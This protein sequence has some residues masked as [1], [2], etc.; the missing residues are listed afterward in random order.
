[1]LLIK[2]PT[3]LTSPDP[4]TPLVPDIVS[5]ML[6][7]LSANDLSL[8]DGANVTSW[9]ASDGTAPSGFKTFNQKGSNDN[10]P[11]F[12]NTNGPGGGKCVEANGTMILRNSGLAS[13]QAQP[14]TYG[15]VYRVDA[16]AASTL[17]TRIIAGQSGKLQNFR[18]SSTNV[19][20]LDAGSGK[21]T[22]SN[23]P[24]GDWLVAVYTLNGSSSKLITYDTEWSGNPG[25]HALD[26]IGFFG[27]DGNTG[28]NY[29]DGAVAHL[30]IHNRAFTDAELQLLYSKL[31]S[32]YGI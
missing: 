27:S 24:L 7:K 14:V 16:L 6:I 25:T 26:A 32:D 15:L 21:A 30:Q 10:W 9:V 12:H 18:I 3:S 29:L 4:D 22:I 19:L 13:D 5:D 11:T 17:N 31:K 1:M 23:I 28:V 8:S 2:C 20:Y